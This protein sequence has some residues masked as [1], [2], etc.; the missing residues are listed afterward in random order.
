MPDLAALAARA[1]PL[2]DL[3]NL[4]DTC[5]D[6]AI[7]ALCARAVTPHGTV[8]AV[9][10][11]PQFVPVARKLLKGTD[12]KVATVANFPRGL[13]DPE[14]AARDTAAAFADGAHEADVV[15]PYHALLAGDGMAVTRLVEAAREKVPRGRRLKT[16]L[17]TGEIKDG[18]LI[19]KAA[20]LAL[21]AGAHFIKTSTGKTPVSA[22]PEAARIML[23]AIKASRKKAGFKASGGIR[24]T[25]DAAI[26]LALADE[27]MGP[28]W[29][30][31]ATF[32]FGASGLLDDLL[33]RLGGKAKPPAA[34]SG[35]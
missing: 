4:N 5:D 27:I 32:R 23:E 34:P 6:A 22:T 21:E 7:H 25:A 2:L 8:A 16:I 17:E 18:A 35:Y 11:W 33:A 20:R 9:C 13:N 12:V 19:A 24:T 29:A 26:Y 14:A 15:I 30:N 31:P 10:I 1:L 3:T 28:D